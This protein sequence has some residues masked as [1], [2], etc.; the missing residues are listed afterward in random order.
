MIEKEFV[1]LVMEKVAK[2]LN[3]AV[4]AKAEVL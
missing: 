4:L 2:T 3:N 1:R